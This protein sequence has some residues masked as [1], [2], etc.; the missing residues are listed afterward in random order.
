MASR[1]EERSTLSA[2][3]IPLLSNQ[4]ATPTYPN[5]KSTE[6]VSG[7]Q[8]LGGTDILILQVGLGLTT[9]L[10]IMGNQFNSRLQARVVERL[11]RRKL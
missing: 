4:A 9:Q 8:N 11:T 1:N 2:P 3:G 10:H 5:T 7:D 6:E